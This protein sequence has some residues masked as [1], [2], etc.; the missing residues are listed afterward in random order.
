VI[1]PRYHEKIYIII[2]N[3]NLPSSMY[4]VYKAARPTTL[5]LNA[6]RNIKDAII[7]FIELH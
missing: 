5:N 2:I 6:L 4:I 1:L 7:L 3:L